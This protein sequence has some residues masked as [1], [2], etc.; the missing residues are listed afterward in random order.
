[1]FPSI[2]VNSL[3]DG[4][5]EESSEGRGIIESR[6]AL[7]SLMTEEPFRPNGGIQVV[8]DLV[9]VNTRWIPM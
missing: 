3:R 8:L 5:E 4:I 9:W 2:N 1:M 7:V 6:S